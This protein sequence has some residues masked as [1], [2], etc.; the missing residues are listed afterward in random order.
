MHRAA[1]KVGQKKSQVER[2]LMGCVKV[3]GLEL[4]P[5]L[6][7]AGSMRYPLGLVVIWVWTNESHALFF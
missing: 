6:A 3:E 1:K 5:N 2:W 7:G 4:A